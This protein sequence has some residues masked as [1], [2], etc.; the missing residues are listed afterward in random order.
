MCFLRH[1]LVSDLNLLRDVDAFSSRSI[2]DQEKVT[3][4]NLIQF[5]FCK[6]KD[7]FLGYGIEN[8]I[9]VCQT[10][11]QIL[12]ILS[13]FCFSQSSYTARQCGI[14]EKVPIFKKKRDVQMH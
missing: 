2:L 9:K 14:T 10:P 12:N 6:E 7:V 3:N 8:P 4:L 1:Q 11:T 13:S 5:E